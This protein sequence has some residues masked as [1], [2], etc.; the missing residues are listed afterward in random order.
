[1]V[2]RGRMGVNVSPVAGRANPCTDSRLYRARPHERGHWPSAT[3][4][5]G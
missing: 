1:V 3:T 4:P 5:A 2:T